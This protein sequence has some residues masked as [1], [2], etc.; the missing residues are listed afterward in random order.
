MEEKRTGRVNCICFK[1]GYPLA[2]IRECSDEDYIFQDLVCEQCG[3]VLDT[4][5]VAL[6]YT[7]GAIV[8]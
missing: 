3:T 6:K 5:I 8:E 4:Q 7:K 2:Y 1:C